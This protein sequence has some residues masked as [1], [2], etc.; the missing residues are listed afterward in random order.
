MPQLRSVALDP[1]PEHPERAAAGLRVPEIVSVEV[2]AALKH[3]PPSSPAATGRYMFP[4][5]AR[6]RRYSSVSCC[7]ACFQPALPPST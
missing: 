6:E 5:E 4:G 2:D 3:G 7:G 1:A